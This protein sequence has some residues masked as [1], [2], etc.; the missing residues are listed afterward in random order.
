M[1]S[2][3]SSQLP[4]YQP[5]ANKLNDA[6]QRAVHNLPNDHRL[7]GLTRRLKMANTF[8][9]NNAGDLTDCLYRK[10][11][12]QQRRQARLRAQG[13]DDNMDGVEVQ[14]M[15]RTV[16][17]MVSRMER[18]VRMII[19]AR[20]VLEGAEAAL[21]ELDS[22]ITAGR[23]AVAPTQSTLGAS[24]FRRKRELR[25]AESDD[26]DEE[27]DDEAFQSQDIGDGPLI[28]WKKKTAENISIYKRLSKRNRYVS[29]SHVATVRLLTYR[30][31]Y[32]SHNDYIGFRKVIHDA[33]HPEDDAPPM[34]HSSTWFAGSEDEPD[35]N[36]NTAEKTAAAD[37]DDDEDV[38]IASE[39]KS[40]KCPITL[41]TMEDPLSSVKCPHSFERSAILEM[42][43]LSEMRI[44]G[45]GRRGARDGQKAM[46]CPE[47]DVVCTR[48]HDFATDHA[49][50]S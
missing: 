40:L 7:D 32:A 27:S 20:V 21:K 38:A 17:E 3:K 1:H 34:A 14:E 33:R 15:R 24:Q 45:S 31:R 43:E 36:V 11:A 30:P 26:E 25:G 22:N 29:G 2:R 42:L 37:P 18:S 16:E 8:L 39:K 44:G 4:P 13:A 6:A 28:S 49:H 9:G 50:P 47:C 41:L 12:A 48:D 35:T 10:T 46:K 23:G 5:L 19:D